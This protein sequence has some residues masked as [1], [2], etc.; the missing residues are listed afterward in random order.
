MPYSYAWDLETGELDQLTTHAI[1][2]AAK[3]SGNRICFF[4]LGSKDVLLWTFKSGTTM[5]DLA[6]IHDTI[7]LRLNLIFH[8]LLEEILYIVG[9]KSSGDA[10]L[11]SE[12]KAG[13][14]TGTQSIPY[15]ACVGCGASHEVAKPWYSPEEIQQISPYGEYVLKRQTCPVK[16]LSAGA[17]HGLQVL[18]CFNVCDATITRRIFPDPAVRTSTIWHGQMAS[19]V[20]GDDFVDHVLPELRRPDPKDLRMESFVVVSNELLDLNCKNPPV[21]VF[22]QTDEPNYVRE[23]GALR[24]QL[25][26]PGG[27]RKLPMRGYYPTARADEIFAAVSAHLGKTR[28]VQYALS[29]AQVCDEWRPEKYVSE[30][31]IGPSNL[32]F[33]DDYLI[34]GWGGGLRIWSFTS[35]MVNPPIHID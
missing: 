27:K 23:G 28:N 4:F 29:E 26:G 16:C 13:I 1:S 24:R 12:F 30:D 3:T 17:P 15:P 11:I 19:Y 10:T 5:L 33:D 20:T 25:M 7:Y 32:S 14:L 34:L 6:H 18:T 21:P 35:D 2:T 9:Q 8:P 31:G 22:Y